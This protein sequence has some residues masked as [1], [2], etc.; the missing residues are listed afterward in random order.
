MWSGHTVVRALRVATGRMGI[1]VASV[2]LR[3][4][5]PKGEQSPRLEIHAVAK[6]DRSRGH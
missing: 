6:T 3:Q 1:C 4:Q 2:T 5:G